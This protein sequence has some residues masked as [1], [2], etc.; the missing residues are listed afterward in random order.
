MVIAGPKRHADRLV[1]RRREVFYLL[2]TLVRD[3]PVKKNCHAVAIL[4]G[5]VTDGV[6]FVTACGAKSSVISA[7]SAEG[8]LKIAA[9][10]RARFWLK[11]TQPPTAAGGFDFRKPSADRIEQGDHSYPD[12]I[13][14]P[15]AITEV[16]REQL[17]GS[18]HRRQRIK[19]EVKGIIPVAQPGQQ[20]GKYVDEIE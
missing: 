19:H 2:V 3:V 8:D 20:H 12:E 14:G 15:K 18:A 5:M 17:L 7:V 9:C 6:R 13:G 11:V 10:L 4:R 1:S 16:W